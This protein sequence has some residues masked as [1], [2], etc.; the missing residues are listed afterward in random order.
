MGERKQIATEAC[1][2][3]MEQGPFPFTHHDVY[4][5]GNHAVGDYEMVGGGFAYRLAD[6]LIQRERK[7]GRIVQIKRGKWVRTALGGE[8]RA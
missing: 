5:A 6:Q 1:L 4:R 3:R 8:T 2:L 7:A